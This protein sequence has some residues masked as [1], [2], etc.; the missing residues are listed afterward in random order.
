[1][2]DGLEVVWFYLT[3]VAPNCGGRDGRSAG[4]G[5]TIVA[6]PMVLSSAIA[7]VEM[8]RTRNVETWR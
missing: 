3:R 2:V 8:D 5:L 7:G 6:L 4:M 1:M